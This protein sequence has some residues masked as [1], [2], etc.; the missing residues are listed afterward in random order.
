MINP[1]TQTMKI[2]F[3]YILALSVVVPIVMIESPVRY[4]W[5]VASAVGIF[6]AIKF[7]LVHRRC[8]HGFVTN[9]KDGVFFFPFVINPCPVCGDDILVPALK[10]QDRTR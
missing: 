6:L 2:L 5:F 1:K 4:V 9:W 3:S 8:G 10:N 7:S